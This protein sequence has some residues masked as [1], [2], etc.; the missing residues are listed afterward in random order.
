MPLWTQSVRTFRIIQ[1][2]H[3]V[4]KMWRLNKLH[5]HF[6]CDSKVWKTPVALFRMNK[7]KLQ[8]FISVDDVS[9]RTRFERKNIRGCSGYF[10]FRQGDSLR[11]VTPDDKPVWHASKFNLGQLQELTTKITHRASILPSLL[12]RR[13]LMEM[14]ACY[15]YYVLSAWNLEQDF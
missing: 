5:T 14:C 10:G 7:Y 2:T 3:C 1:N 8:C 12:L 6:Y 11:R 4:G 13:T 15:K 9:L